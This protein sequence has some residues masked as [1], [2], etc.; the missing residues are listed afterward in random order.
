MGAHGAMK[1]ALLGCERFRAAL[2]MSSGAYDEDAEYKQGNLRWPT[3]I[4]NPEG[5]IF[6]QAKK[7]VTEGKQLPEFFISCGMKD[8][9]LERV[10]KNAELL[11]SFGYT[12]HYEEDPRY[13]H[14]WDLWEQI[15]R[16]ALGTQL[17][18]KRQVLFP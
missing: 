3:H 6:L 4:F 2:I 5:K 7:N 8:S 1:M 10:R 18:L 14:E 13:A 9:N 15:L 12:V 11:K 16:N 17:P